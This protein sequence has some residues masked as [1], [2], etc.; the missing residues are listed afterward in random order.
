[1]KMM[2]G[3]TTI[4][5]TAMAMNMAA[6]NFTLKGHFT[7]VRNDTVLISYTK[8]EPDKQ[9]IETKIPINADGRFSYSCDIQNAYNAQLVVQS[10]NSKAFFFFVPGESVEIA[11]PS[12]SDND[13]VIGGSAFYQKWRETREVFLPFYKEFD[14]ARAKYDK[15]M[16][17][18]LDKA[19]L[20]SERK[21][22]NR[23][24]NKRLWS[25]AGQ[26]I[27]DHLDDEVSVTILLDQDYTDILPAIRMLSPEVRHGRFKDYIDGIASMFSRLEKEMAAEKSATL[28]LEEGKYV[29][30]FTLK[31]IN[32]NDFSL[33]SILGK[34]KYIVIDFWGS[35][36]A[37]CIKG[38]PE[39]AEYYDKYKDRLEIV[40]VACYD[41][42]E[43]WKDAVNRN[44]IP[45]L[46]V[47]SYDGTTEVRFGVTA[48]PYK[49]VVSPEGKVMKCFKGETDEFYEMLDDVLK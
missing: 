30:D 38:F 12:T 23:E 27:K 42:E 11:G 16:A 7:D 10:N 20:D 21:A 24:I 44:N 13:W 26:Y 45:W 18:G 14:A 2:K 22:A 1:M 33:H 15:G 32:G 3:I 39:M 37:W 6:Q 34:G 25:V 36:C 43:K 48:Y 46:H 5:L 19:M 28:E 49:I 8:R 35:W 47:F 40:G 9:Q 29:P 31:D 4:M 41:K 17:D